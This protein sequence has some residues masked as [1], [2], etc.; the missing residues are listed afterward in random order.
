[1]HFERDEGKNRHNLAKH[2]ISFETARLVFED[3]QLLVRE[4]RVISA[5]RAATPERRA[6]DEAYES[7][8]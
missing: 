2:K 5:R 6:Y 3:P 8:S 1:M 4:D 7:P